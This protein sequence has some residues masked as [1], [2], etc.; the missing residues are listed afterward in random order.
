MA[1]T[2]ARI[3]DGQG[4]KDV[5]L[6]GDT[7][8]T[9]ARRDTFFWLDVL[10]AEADE[11]RA[12]G[13]A[14][15]LHPLAIDDSIQFG[16]RAKLDPYDDY[17]LLVAFGW[18]PDEDGL[19]EVHC[20]FSERYLVTVRR[21]E[22]PALD[23]ACDRIVRA[24]HAHKDPVMVLHEVVD[25]LAASFNEPL[26]TLDDRLEDIETEIVERPD[27]SQMREILAMRRELATF[28]K[29][30]GPQRD[31][32]GRLTTGVEELPGMTDDAQ[33]AFRDLYD[34][35]Y[36]LGETMDASRDVMTGALDVYLSS[37]SNRLSVI[38]K[39]LTVIATIFLPLSFLTGF[40]GQN[41][42]FMVRHVGSW[43]AFLVLGI[44]LE[45]LM[46]LAILVLF[47]KRGWF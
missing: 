33:H 39:Q 34:H 27:Q 14:F 42:G 3:V 1:L 7:L 12:I 17:V 30:I 35:M 37:S 44:G 38:N 41:F 26:E 43:A 28:R 46:V 45:L 5:A 29:A 25:S 21:D 2:A 13:A 9:A 24:L 23:A 8:G 32:F 36:R 16:Q 40:F 22:A 47:K 31:L 11:I 4:E 10:G 15:G 19:V 6:D 20:Y 18:S